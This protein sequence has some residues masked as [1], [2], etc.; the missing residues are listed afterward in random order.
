[1]HFTSLPKCYTFGIYIGDPS[2][3][4]FLNQPTYIF[5]LNFSFMLYITCSGVVH[6][7]ELQKNPTFFLVF[8]PAV[9]LKFLAF[10]AV[11]GNSTVHNTMVQT[12]SVKSEPHAALIQ[13]QHETSL[14]FPLQEMFNALVTARMPPLH[15]FVE[16]KCKSPKETVSSKAQVESSA[17]TQTVCLCLSPHSLPTA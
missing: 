8:F 10:L 2:T 9:P 16:D 1:M 14:N 4:T 3:H 5:L 15:S 12:K 17:V 6:W 13:P 7:T 11:T